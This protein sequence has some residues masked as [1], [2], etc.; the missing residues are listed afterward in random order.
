MMIFIDIYCFCS[1]VEF[2][3]F[4]MVI[5]TTSFIDWLLR[6][7]QL[8]YYLDYS[9]PSCGMGKSNENSGH[10]ADIVC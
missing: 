9:L 7:F 2:S 6:Y 8:P 10:I 3:P 4:L 5:I 1:E